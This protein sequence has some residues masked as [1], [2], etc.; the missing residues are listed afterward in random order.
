[1]WDYFEPEEGAWYRFALHGAACWLRRDGEEWRTAVEARL[2]EELSGEASGPERLPAPEGLEFA[3]AVAKGGRVRLRPRL[4]ERPCLVIAR[5]EITVHRGSAVRFE[6]E[7]PLRYALELED[8]PELAE[9]E[10]FILRPA[11]FGDR[12]DGVACWRIPAAIDP[13]CHGESRSQPRA[14]AGARRP[15]SK[16]VG[17]RPSRAALARCAVTVHAG[18]L[19]SVTLKRFAIYVELLGL[20]AE[21]GGIRTEEVHL[22]GTGEGGLRTGVVPPDQALARERL[23]APRVGQGELLVRR[24]AD[25]LRSVTGL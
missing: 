13:E 15:A 21:T 4:P 14:Q 20:Y 2:L 17:P 3:Y 6:V 22:D 8:G 11:W 23:A 12:R 9:L 24:G 25:F 1:M 19:P 18:A 7:L 16:L 10:P 5:D